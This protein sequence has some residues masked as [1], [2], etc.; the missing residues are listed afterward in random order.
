MHSEYITYDN[1]PENARRIGWGLLPEY[2][3]GDQNAPFVTH[4][5]DR[6]VW[7]FHTKQ[8]HEKS[9]LNLNITLPFEFTVIG[10]KTVANIAYIVVTRNTA[11]HQFCTYEIGVPSKAGDPCP[12]VDGG[13]HHSRSAA[14]EDMDS[15]VSHWFRR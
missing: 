12:C 1:T 7:I 8:E 5:T 10:Y 9:A 4:N 11:N 6:G 3:E 15:R 14:F 2:C 13:Y